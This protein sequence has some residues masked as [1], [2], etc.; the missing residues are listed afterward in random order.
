M[1]T[2]TCFEAHEVLEG[3][4]VNT[5]VRS[6]REGGFARTPETVLSST[7]SENAELMDTSY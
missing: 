3:G 6:F 5:M 4:T 1:R 7:E 2:G